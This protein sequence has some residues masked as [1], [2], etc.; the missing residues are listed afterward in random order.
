VNLNKMSYGSV[1][2]SYGQYCAVARALDVV[3]D[4]W[5]LL[6]VRELLL[7]GAC[8][9]TDLLHGLPG[10][11]TNLLADR[12]RELA[13]AGLLVREEAPPP[14]ATTLFALTPRGEQLRVVL[15]QL[16][17]WGA[18]LMAEP[19][20]DDTFRSHWLA[21]PV[22]LYL[23]DQMPDD[24][25]V[26][27]ELRIGDETVTLETVEGTVRTRPGPAD[28]PELVLAGDPQTILG[29]LTG[30]IDLADAEERGLNHHGNTTILRRLRARQPA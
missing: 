29:L 19:L 6:I 15:D 22:G 27:I 30:H 12:L 28:N 2:R 20:G 18:E 14:I 5:N 11:A 13:R 3:G 26:T 4:R 7:R 24:P 8:R 25:P 21:F 17:R 16:G 1:V 10:I 23:K 9:Y